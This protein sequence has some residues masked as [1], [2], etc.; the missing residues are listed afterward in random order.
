MRIRLTKEAADYII[1]AL[2]SERSH[3]SI[4]YDEI[5]NL[6][7]GGQREAWGK[8]AEEDAFVKNLIKRLRNLR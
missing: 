4:C 1:A 7:E 5:R 8:D 2:K 3:R 6:T